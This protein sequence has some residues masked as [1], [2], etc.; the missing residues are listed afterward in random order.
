MWHDGK[1][2]SGSFINFEFCLMSCLVLRLHV[3]QEEGKKSE[4]LLCLKAKHQSRI[5]VLCRRPDCELQKTVGTFQANFLIIFSWGKI[6]FS[7][8]HNHIIITKQK[9]ILLSSNSKP[10]VFM[11]SV[12][13]LVKIYAFETIRTPS[14][15][16]RIHKTPC[17]SILKNS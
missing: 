10:S 15:T 5:L 9:F 12:I 11:Y 4:L 3:K 17:S 7:L 8:V 13:K 6:S 16:I 2:W 14:K 1:S